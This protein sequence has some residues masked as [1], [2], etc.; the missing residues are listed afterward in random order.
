MKANQ[1]FIISSLFLT[2]LLL[3]LQTNAE[4][5]MNYYIISENADELNKFMQEQDIQVN[6]YFGR[7]STFEVTLNEDEIKAIKQFDSTAVLQKERNY[8]ITSD[9]VIPSI[10]TVKA[11]PSNTTPYTGKNVK[12][13]I[14]DSGIDT[15]HRD[16]KVAGGYCALSNQCATGIPYDDNHGH[17]THVAGVIAAKANDTGTV[18]IAP[19]AQI[20]SIKVLNE[21]GKGTTGSIIRGIEWAIENDLDILN[22]SITST[23]YDAVME[24]TLKVA[25]EKGMLLVGA[26][27]NEALVQP[28]GNSVTYPAKFSSVI[29]VGAVTDELAKLP[30]SSIGA[31]LEIA[32]PGYAIFSTYPNEWDFSDGKQDGYT[33]LS[34]TSMAAPHVTGVLALYR[35]RFPSMTN[36]QLR[37]LLTSLAKD[38]GTPGRDSSFG[39]GLVQ[40]EK[41]I[42]GSPQLE[43]KVE[44]GKVEISLAN[45]VTGL[46]L[47]LNNKILNKQ[48]NKWTIY[49]VQGDYPIEVSYQT[50]KGIK[51]KERLN[52]Q[53]TNPIYSDVK[54]TQWFSE[55]IGNLANKEQINGYDDGSFKPYQEI[56][57]AEAAVLIGR[58][59]SLDGALR[60]TTFS[61]VSE[62]SFAAGYIQSALDAG[63][64]SGYKDGTFK[65]DDKVTRGEMAILLAKA[66]KLSPTTSNK[67][68]FVDISPSMAAYPYILPIIDAKVTVGYGDNTFKPYNK[69]TRSEFAAFLARIQK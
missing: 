46:Q 16:L 18:G 37:A 22:L 54:R 28:K 48:N 62:K 27:G 2:L 58:A 33:H 34:G 57:R 25:Y 6:D 41:D 20:Y 31:E 40:Y 53:I 45:S 38:L 42:E 60:K 24:N 11:A 52:L 29:A 14:L 66:F 1:I 13:G 68:K 43:T 56:T 3:P 64:I 51:M 8:N 69:I 55:H 61:D 5:D 59:K 12:I 50:A 65:P 19:N 67:S 32:A 23:T 21:F 47:T 35:E 63:I 30:E 36:V 4:S 26:A 17:G 39:F 44:K 49:G 15:E 10:T 9:K 7:F